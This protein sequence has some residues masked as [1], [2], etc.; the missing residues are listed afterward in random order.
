MFE[1]YDAGVSFRTSHDPNADL[2]YTVIANDSNGT[3]PMTKLLA[4]RL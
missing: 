3:W 1:G 2:T 4:T